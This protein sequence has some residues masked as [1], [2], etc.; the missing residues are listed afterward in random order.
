MTDVDTTCCISFE[1]L[2]VQYIRSIP[3]T[4]LFSRILDR[5]LVVMYLTYISLRDQTD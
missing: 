4:L 5:I 2:K 1:H 3:S